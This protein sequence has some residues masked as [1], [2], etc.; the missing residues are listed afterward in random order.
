MKIQGIAVALLIGLSACQPDI[1]TPEFNDADAVYLNLEKTYI[2][3]TDG[4]FEKQVKKSQKLLT[5]RAFHSLYGQTDIYYNPVSDS[6]VVEKAETITPDGKTV[7]VPDN[8][9]V[10]MLPSFA[11]GSSK[12]SHLRHRAVVHTA[13]ERG[14]VINSSYS[15]YSKA[16][17]KPALMGLEILTRDCPVMNFKLVVKVPKG[18]TVHFKN[19]NLSS[20]PKI[21]KKGKYMV[22]TW[23]ESNIAQNSPE[24]FGTR[25]NAGKKQ[26]LFSSADSLFPL[27][28]EFTSQKA[29]TFETNIEM[30]KSVIERLKGKTD[31]FE[32]IAV[33]QKIVSEEIQTIP[34]PLSLTEYKIRP[35][36]QT[37]KSMAGTKEEKAVLLCA[38]IR[39]TGWKATPVAA[40]P[41]YIFKED[42][43]INL[44]GNLDLL[45]IDMVKFPIAGI[46]Y[47]IL[48]DHFQLQ[49]VSRNYPSHYFIP[50][51]M[52]YSKVNLDKF[53]IEEFQLSWDGDLT[54]VKNTDLKGKFDANFMGPANPYVGLKMNPDAIN[55]IYSGKGT[56]ER[57]HPKSTVLSFKTRISDAAVMFGNKIQIDLPFSNA[58][59]DSWGIKYLS[60]NRDTDF[61]LPFPI[62]EFQRI[63]IKVPSNYTP[64]DLLVDFSIKNEVGRVS[65][66]H[67]YESGKIMTLRT[68]LIQRTVIKTDEY[69]KLKELL[70]P[71][72]NPDY[73]RVIM[74]INDQ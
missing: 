70:D 72:L 19:F 43:S 40:V 29:F 66:R 54:L 62:R 2:L 1:I 65:I 67:S 63:S 24:P 55:R 26:I 61:I 27:F 23:Q 22:Y 6:V 11:R 3:H 56:I 64:F 7:Q 37:W 59:F 60:Q 32:K 46:D 15:I 50:L 4:S 33:L 53:P 20:D 17:S 45:S 8:G 68:L 14:A 48:A 5:Y 71:W 21:R 69:N 44:I 12:F 38:L 10:D 31:T 47:Y 25:F 9:Y 18:Q 58:G 36:V 35:A 42:S 34:V 13:L 49:D 28:N 73:R 39:S 16:D 30:R 57:V 51:E 41:E 52:G 74:D